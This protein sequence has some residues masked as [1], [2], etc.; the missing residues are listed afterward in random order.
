[1]WNANPDGTSVMS[2]MRQ[3]L[4]KTFAAQ[5]VASLFDIVCDEVHEIC[6]GACVKLWVRDEPSQK[7]CLAHS[8]VPASGQHL[9]SSDVLSEDDPE[10]GLLAKGF[11]DFQDSPGWIRRGHSEL[12]VCPDAKGVAYLHLTTPDTPAVDLAFTACVPRGVEGD[13]SH[14]RDYFD[15]LGQTFSRELVRLRWERERHTVANVLELSNNDLSREKF[16][17]EVASVLKEATRA[18]GCSIFVY[19]PHLDCVVLGG[20]TNGLFAD[21]PNAVLTKEEELAIRYGRSEGITGFIFATSETVRLYDADDEAEIQLFNSKRKR[22]KEKLVPARRSSE[23][24]HASRRSF[25]GVPVLLSDGTCVGVIRLHGREKPQFFLPSDERLVE[26]IAP[27]V[28]QAIGQH[29]AMSDRRIVARRASTRRKQVLTSVNKGTGVQEQLASLA[30]HACRLFAG[31]SSSI[32]VPDAQEHNLVVVA[33]SSTR[34]WLDRQVK[35]PVEK[36]ICG[37]VYRLKEAYASAC[38]NTDDFFDP[39]KEFGDDWLDDVQSEMCSPIIWD[40]LVL[41]VLNVDSTYLGAFGSDS[42][43]GKQKLATLEDLC[44]RA[45][46]IILDAREP[47]RRDLLGLDLD[48][49]LHDVVGD[50]GRLR[51]QLGRV[52]RSASQEE[53]RQLKSVVDSAAGKADYWRTMSELRTLDRAALREHNAGE[54]FERLRRLTECSDAGVDF[55]FDST[56]A[57]DGQ[58]VRLNDVNLFLAVRVFLDNAVA[59]GVRGKPITIAGTLTPS[60]AVQIAVKNFGPPLPAEV[61]DARGTAVAPNPRGNGVGLVLAANLALINGGCV[62]YSN[63]LTGPVCKIQFPT[64]P[65]EMQC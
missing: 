33:D 31:C 42:P 29:A 44:G 58:Q 43:F 12:P 47:S 52:A 10:A 3:V 61:A 53:S 19:E 32:L 59:Y 62:E 45:A 11:R 16:F 49:C 18:T 64:V 63:V 7:I 50:F 30:G 54:L 24:P 5:S 14:L 23:L 40:G 38:T 65:K 1:M 15:M 57:F 48:A 6:P 46:R 26:A 60:K 55:Q 4:K 28:G 39:L 17:S 34:E 22:A 35:I 2:Q 21:D 13:Y 25:L 9:K 20:T 56:N 51:T 27:F 41:G 36:G 8:C 37:R